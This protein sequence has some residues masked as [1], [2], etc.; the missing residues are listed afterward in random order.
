M[1]SDFKTNLQK[2]TKL[3]VILWNLEWKLRWFYSYLRIW[4][5]IRP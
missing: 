5:I 3:D 1:Q 2:L 4:I